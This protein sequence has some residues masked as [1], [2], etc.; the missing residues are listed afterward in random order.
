MRRGQ[1]RGWHLLS[2]HHVQGPGQARFLLH[3]LVSH[4]TEEKTEPQR[5]AG[6][7]LATE[8]PRQPRPPTPMLA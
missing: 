8:E 1:D 7:C 3:L 6:T 5:A 4:L 2:T